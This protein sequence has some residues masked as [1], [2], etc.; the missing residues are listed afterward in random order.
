MFINIYIFLIRFQMKVLVWFICSPA[1]YINII[2]IENSIRFEI[3]HYGID[4]GDKVFF[5]VKFFQ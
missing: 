4:E 3:F 2:Q 5:S 1:Q